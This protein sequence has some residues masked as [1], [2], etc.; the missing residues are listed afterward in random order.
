MTSWNDTRL[1]TEVGYNPQEAAKQD[2]G[3]FWISWSDV[4]VYFQNL[5]LSW[6]PALFS[7]RVSTHRAWPKDLGP[8][9]DTFNVGEN[10]QYI[11]NLSE[12]AIQKKASIWILVSRHVTKQEQEGAE[13]RGQ[14]CRQQLLRIVLLTNIISRF[15]GY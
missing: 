9:D 1:R 12:S 4:L 13:V 6:N 7:H 10:P 2:D 3:V 15:K 5:H 8:Q 11:M 14:T